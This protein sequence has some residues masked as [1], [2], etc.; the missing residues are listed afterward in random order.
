MGNIVRSESR[1]GRAIG[2]G[3]DLHEGGNRTVTK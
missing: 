1:G 2:V 3:S